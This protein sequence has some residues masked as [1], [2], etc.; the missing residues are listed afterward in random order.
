MNFLATIGV[1]AFVSFPSPGMLV[2]TAGQSDIKAEWGVS[3][4]SGTPHAPHEGF[5][6]GT[7]RLLD[8]DDDGGVAL[9]KNV[10]SPLGGNFWLTSCAAAT[11]TGGSLCLPKE[12]TSDG[13]TCSCQ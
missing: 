11:C 9:C 13:G 12:W 1:L 3:L 6:A 7:S 4:D 2:P 8:N 10:R 5:P